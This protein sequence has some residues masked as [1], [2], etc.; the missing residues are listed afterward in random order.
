MCFVCFSRK[1]NLKE[2]SPEVGGRKEEP[3]RETI[4]RWFFNLEFS[5]HR[6]TGIMQAGLGKQD[7]IGQVRY[8]EEEKWVSGSEFGVDVFFIVPDSNS[9]GGM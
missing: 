5:G 3:S 1:S 7:S 9:G 2:E 4:L 6:Q 8:D